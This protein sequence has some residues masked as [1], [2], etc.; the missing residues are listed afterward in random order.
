[1]ETTGCRIITYPR[2]GALFSLYDVADIH[3]GTKGMSMDRLCHDRERIK[4]DPWALWFEGGDYADFIHPNDKRFDPASFDPSIKVSDLTSYAAKVA[5]Q[6]TEFFKP[7]RHKCLG[8]CIGNHDLKYLT[9]TSQMQIHEEICREMRV[10][11]MGYSGWADLYF[12]H[13]PGRPV[14][15]KVSVAPPKRFTARLRVLVHHGFSTAASPGGK[16]N[17]MKR[18]VDSVEADL[19]MMSHV[20]EQLAKSFTRLYP[21]ENCSSIQAKI[22]MGMITGTYLR[23]YVPGMTSYG[24]QRGYH[25]TTLGASR[26]TYSP[27]EMKLTVESVGEGVGLRGK[28]A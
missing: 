9:R 18:L 27:A 12:V 13:L 10:P 23:T 14:A 4:G 19:V 28:A 25:P 16:I 21:D 26:A 22:T 15:V 3:W 7:I 6:V 24:E 5:R 2:E 20:H 8:W 17:A 11:N 1:M